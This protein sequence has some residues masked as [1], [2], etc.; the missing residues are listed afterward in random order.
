MPTPTSTRLNTP[1]GRVHFPALYQA[2]DRFETGTA[3]YQ[4]TL[5]FDKSEDLTA[6]HA[7]AVQAA[8]NKFSI[9]EAEAKKLVDGKNG[10]FLDGDIDA[11]DDPHFAGK[12]F[13]RTNATRR[14]EVVDQNLNPLLGPDDEN[15]I[16]AGCY[17]RASVTAAGWTNGGKKGVSFF[18]NNVQKRAD[19]DRIDGTRAAADDFGDALDEEVDPL[20]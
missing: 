2:V 6:L 3:K 8:I 10:P 12:T 13:I 14:P 20:S 17:A 7:A 4:L 15:A 11:A 1:T 19:G 9:S 18:L 16:F 5:A